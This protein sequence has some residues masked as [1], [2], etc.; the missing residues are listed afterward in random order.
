[1]HSKT[2]EFNKWLMKKILEPTHKDYDPKGNSSRA[3]ITRGMK[4][5]IFYQFKKY[6][7]S[8]KNEIK[9]FEGLDT[10][11]GYFVNL[12]LMFFLAPLVPLIKGIYSYK[13]AVEDYKIIFKEHISDIEEI[14]K[15][16]KLWEILI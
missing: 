10:P 16:G 6:P 4:K 11:I 9:N 15:K 14:K 3:I 1:M 7:N 8:L 2:N 5:E 13:K 12:F